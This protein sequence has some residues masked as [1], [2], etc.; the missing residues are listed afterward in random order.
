[1]NQTRYFPGC[2]LKETA[3][4]FEM[5]ALYVMERLGRPL[6]ELDRWNCCGTVFSLTADDLM[7]HLA[8]VR[9]LIRAQEAGAHELVA[10]CAMCYNTLGRVGR[11]VSTDREALDKINAFMNSEADYDGR[12]GVRHLLQVLR[13]DVGWDR[14]AAAAECPLDGFA[15]AGYYGCTLL[16]P[17]DVAVDDP[18]RPTVMTDA[19]EA[20]GATAVPFPFAGECCGSYQTV[21]RRDL[22][23]ERSYRVLRAARRAGADTIATACPLCQHNL[24]EARREL[25]ER[26]GIGSLTIVY[27]TELLAAAF[28]IAPERLP[29]ALA[30]RLAARATAQGEER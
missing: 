4:S 27:F 12:V 1:M 20:V 21:D 25:G 2:S 28:G 10:L 17:K 29:E 7:H 18:E 5:S 16:R 11:R 22:S 19:I 9:N 15:V 23:T 8:S 14:L 6:V 24:E 26:D 3:R 30:A 13:D